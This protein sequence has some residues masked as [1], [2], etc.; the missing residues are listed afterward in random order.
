MFTKYNSP[1]T[2][3]LKMEIEKIKLSFPLDKEA[4]ADALGHYSSYE[5]KYG[6]ESVNQFLPIL[7]KQGNA[8]LAAPGIRLSCAL[9]RHLVDSRARHFQ[10]ANI[11]YGL[12]PELAA[13]VPKRE[14][15]NRLADRARTDLEA[16]AA[17]HGLVEHRDRDEVARCAP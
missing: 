12:F 10:P 3:A 6:E 13:R 5:C 9:A 2:I 15:R 17:T 11:N 1:Q 16:W 14:R 4:I 8:F 7:R